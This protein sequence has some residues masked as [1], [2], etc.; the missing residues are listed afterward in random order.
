MT[1]HFTITTNRRNEWVNITK[2]VQSLVSQAGIKEGVCIIF[3]PHTTAGV[4]INENAD[5]D[6]PH[7][8]QYGLSLLAPTRPDYQH[9]EG[10]SDAHIKSSLVGHSLPLIVS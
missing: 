5:P 3:I 1:T 6:V 9:R 10:N 2:N 4:T 8:V 7:D